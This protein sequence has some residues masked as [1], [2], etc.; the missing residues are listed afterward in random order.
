MID[1][2]RRD[3]PDVQHLDID[4]IVG[5]LQKSVLSESTSTSSNDDASDGWPIASTAG[6]DTLD[7][8]SPR[9]AYSLTARIA[10]LLYRSLLPSHGPA[11]SFRNIGL[12]LAQVP[13]RLL[14]VPLILI[15]DPLLR[16]A[17]ALVIVLG[18]A[19]ALGSGTST[20]QWQCVSSVALMAFAGVIGVRANTAAMSGSTLLARLDQIE[21]NHPGYNVGTWRDALIAAKIGRWKKWSLLLAGVVLV[22]SSYELVAVLLRR[23]CDG[24]LP[25]LGVTTEA[26]L[27]WVF[28]VLF[29]QHFLNQ[30]AYRVQALPRRRAGRKPLAFGAGIAAIIV[31]GVAEC[32]ARLQDAQI[33]EGQRKPGIST[34]L[35]A[36]GVPSWWDRGPT[37]W[38]VAS[39]AVALLTFLSLWGWTC[40]WQAA[41]CIVASAVAAGLLQGRF[42]HGGR[43]YDLLPTLVWIVAVA[44]VHPCIEVRRSDQDYG[45]TGR[46]TL[47]A[48]KLRSEVGGLT[49]AAGAPGRL[50]A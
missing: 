39:I 28:F 11:L 16:L 38:V 48:L 47:T 34:L 6:A 21:I 25:V 12:R 23:S 49:G 50:G 32:I 29:V 33:A 37:T 36:T 35:E 9:Y 41:G 26:F 27:A 10:P 31:V 7:A 5:D 2:S 14:A 44:L 8:V 24:T 20:W 42:D 15:A 43:F 4:V 17:W 3:D 19:A 40:W 30:R 46:L 13:L 1:S 45:E 18:S 22:T